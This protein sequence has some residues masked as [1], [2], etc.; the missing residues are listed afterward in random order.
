MV[1]VFAVAC[2]VL[3]FAGALAS[4]WYMPTLAKGRQVS[5]IRSP[6]QLHSGVAGPGQTS[7]PAGLQPEAAAQ[8]RQSLLSQPNGA[9][10][11]APTASNEALDLE[12]SLT[13][14]Q[15]VPANSSSASGKAELQIDLSQGRLCYQLEDVAGPAMNATAVQVQKA[16]AGSTGPV[17]VS[18][19]VPSGG[20]SSDCISGLDS[21]VLRD[22]VDHVEGYYVNVR[23]NASP[24]GEIRGQLARE[25][26]E[27]AE[28]PDND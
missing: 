5:V 23:T 11:A 9:Q 8:Y 15:E 26:E 19:R 7:Q 18:L 13:G 21:N 1:A 4:V 17:V 22:I 27:P 24:E 2:G 3:L 16:P 10:A 20:E 12:S 28:N 6:G 25:A 14:A